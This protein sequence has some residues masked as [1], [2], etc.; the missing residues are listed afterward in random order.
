MQ[1][2]GPSPS[3]SNLRHSYGFAAVSSAHTSA[4]GRFPNK[5]VTNYWLTESAN[6]TA[7]KQLNRMQTIIPANCHEIP[8]PNQGHDMAIAW[9]WP[10]TLDHNPKQNRS[11]LTQLNMVNININNVRLLQL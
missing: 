10:R 1:G 3:G 7:G 5:D 6:S 8:L 11:S 4:K 2:G 9:P